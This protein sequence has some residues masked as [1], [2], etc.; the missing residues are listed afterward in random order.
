MPLYTAIS[1]ESSVSARASRN[2]EIAQGLT[3]TGRLKLV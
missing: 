1:Q 3:E 2:W